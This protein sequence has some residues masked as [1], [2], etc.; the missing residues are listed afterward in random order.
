M[1][2]KSKEGEEGTKDQM[3]EHK[4]GEGGVGGG[5]GNVEKLN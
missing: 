5:G 3:C 2:A 4:C 1:S